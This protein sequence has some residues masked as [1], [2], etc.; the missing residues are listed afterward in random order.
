MVN[1]AELETQSSL[2]KREGSARH[3]CSVLRLFP[4]P[5]TPSPFLGCPIP[6]LLTASK[7][8]ASDCSLRSM[9]GTRSA[10]GGACYGTSQAHSSP[11]SWLHPGQGV[12]RG[13]S[14]GQ[15]SLQLRV[16]LGGCPRPDNQP[17]GPT[18]PTSR[19]QHPASLA[20]PP[21]CYLAQ[22][23]S[24]KGGENNERF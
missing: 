6:Q 9:W 21:P 22:V 3:L 12:G 5:Q 18:S 14:L 13:L 8:L 16:K 17:L 2:R 11:E 15:Q 20:L 24:A 4:Q 19:A 7:D 10:P 23:T 1:R